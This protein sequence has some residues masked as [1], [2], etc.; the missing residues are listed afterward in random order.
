MEVA[1]I[2]LGVLPL[3]VEAVKSYK[4]TYEKVKIFQHYSREVSLF[5][6]L[7]I[8]RVQNLLSAQ[9]QVFFNE[10]LLLLGMVVQDDYKLHALIEDGSD[11]I[12]E[13]QALDLRLLRCLGNNHETCRNIIDDI[14]DSLDQIQ[15][16]LSCFDVLKHHQRSNERFK[17]TVRRLRGGIT[18]SFEKAQYVQSI[19]YLRDRN[20]DLKT[21]RNQI[22]EFVQRQ[23]CSSREFTLCRIPDRFR[24]IQEA[25]TTLHEALTK[26]LHQR[27]PDADYSC[28]RTLLCVEADVCDFVRLDLAISHDSA[29]SSQTVE[30][31]AW[32]CVKST[33][34]HVSPNNVY[35]KRRLQECD[36][37]SRIDK[38]LADG[39]T[40]FDIPSVVARDSYLPPPSKIRECATNNKS[41][42]VPSS[43]FSGLQEKAS[44]VRKRKSA[45]RCHTS[46]IIGLDDLTAVEAMSV[47]L[48]HT[49]NICGYFKQHTCDPTSG[50][51]R[52]VGYLES[53]E[54]VKHFF[55]A[56]T[57]QNSPQSNLK[58]QQIPKSLDHLIN[59]ATDDALSVVDQLK[60]AHKL[61]V[62]VLQFQSTPWLNQ[63]WRL[64]DLCYFESDKNTIESAL[65]T[66]HLGA[67]FPKDRVGATCMEGA[68]VLPHQKQ[69]T[70]CVSVSIEEAQDLYGVRNTMLFSLGISLLEI[71]H[72]KLLPSFRE[73]RD[74]NDVVTARR[75]AHGTTPLGS[76]YQRILQ[77]CLSCDFGV[78][79]D[80]G[81]N[82]LQGGV[83]EN[84]VAEL[85]AMIRG[86]TI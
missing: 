45:H 80:L 82:E 16:K 15:R 26:A 5:H 72:R 59:S 23:L 70:P 41:Q 9:K 37:S 30:P 75:L 11:Y 85:E 52:C 8:Y 33:T 66:L 73:P 34:T 18:I 10:Y 39:L 12:S 55:Y 54:A 69:G 14:L 86:L 47:N 64:G 67:R 60:F 21:L 53:S 19:D 32:F 13:D 44:V 77:K 63:E 36:L 29:R 51:E 3:I 83:H 43:S 28:H 78:G 42:R 50:E 38:T 4:A 84:I 2:V 48:C 58:I 65:R 1:G 56:P 71:G 17:D 76:K 24:K 46:S 81:M 27:C 35:K 31:P 7:R 61:A 49:S 22:G 74:T 57:R 68:E 79:S 40:G 25:S 62:A 6:T 20:T